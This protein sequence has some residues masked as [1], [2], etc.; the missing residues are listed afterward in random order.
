M[1]YTNPNDFNYDDT[2]EDW[3]NSS[4]IFARALS[5]SLEENEGIVVDMKGNMEYTPDP[6]VE[7]VIVFKSQN[8]IC[9]IECEDDI[10]E[11]RYVTIHKINPN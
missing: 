9:I 4:M 6:S 2:P 10:E 5:L 1:N 8:Q 7:K 11:G 3:L